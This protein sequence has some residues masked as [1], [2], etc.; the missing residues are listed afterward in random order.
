MAF[1][2][3]PPLRAGLRTL[4]QSS[5]PTSVPRGREEL[6]VHD[7][8][9]AR[10]DR[11]ARGIIRNKARQLIGQAGFTPSDREDIE[12]SLTLHLLQRLDAFDPTRRHRNVFVTTVIERRVAN[13]LRDRKAAL[14]DPS[15]V[16]SLDAP[17]TTTD[18]SPTS[19][20][21]GV[22]QA[23]HD[24]RHLRRSRDEHELAQLALDLATVM[25]KWPEDLRD[26]AQRLMSKSTA[27]VARDLQVPRTTLYESIKEIRRRFDDAGLRGYLEK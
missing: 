1:L 4:R 19:L 10:L 18:G 22:K 26:L 27:E 17:G 21:D 2:A 12:Q 11:F 7:D 5:W 8:L 25:E 14:R 6:P 9:D 24:A 16:V 20:A 23:D 13:L 3:L 15:R